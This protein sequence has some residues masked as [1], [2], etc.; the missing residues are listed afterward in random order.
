VVTRQ[1]SVQS[2]ALHPHFFAARRIFAGN[3]IGGCPAFRGDVNHFSLPMNP[4]E[5]R[6]L[7]IFGCGYI[8]SAAARAGAARGAKVIAL[9][10]NADTAALLR[11]DGIETVVS[12]LAGDGWHARIPGGP[13]FVL[14]CVSSGGGGIEAYRHSYVGGAAS[15]LAWVRR[16]GAAGT[17]VYTSSTSV[18]PQ[19]G[20]ATVDETA[21]TEG[22]GERAQ[23]LLQ[24]ENAMRDATGAW[25]RSFVLRLAGIYGPGRH[26]LIEQLR[27]GE[28]AGV[29]EPRLNLIHRDDVVA[30]IFAC[31]AAPADVGGDVFNVADDEPS[32]KSEVVA[33]LAARLAVP[34]PRFTGGSGPAPRRVTS[35]RLIGNA[36]LKSRLGWRPQ[37]RSFRAGYESFLSP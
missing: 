27:S 2:A 11:A 8:G 4:L 3:L 6:R 25:R 26:Q 29:G 31:F 23:L 37:Y 34:S 35:D 36:K 1:S 16:A 15:I 7:V 22:G 14:N 5:G 20:G 32:Q 30:A 9:T 12:D 10:R 13:D 24:A 28:I 21:S 17:A 18:Y 19:G 33:W